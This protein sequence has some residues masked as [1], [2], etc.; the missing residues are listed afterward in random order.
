MTRQEYMKDPTYENHRL[1][2]GQFVTDN[3]RRIV[4]RAIGE[5]RIL[6]STDK[7][8]NDIPLHEWDSLEWS[9]RPMVSAALKQTGNCGCS[10]SDCICIA[11]E[12]A[13]QWK[14]SQ[15]ATN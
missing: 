7:H 5:K 9:I 4:V 8:M 10:L 1:Y 11:K 14:D 6:E 3:L 12:A 13:K 2:C 15:N